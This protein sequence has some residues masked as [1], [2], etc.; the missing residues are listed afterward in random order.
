MNRFDRK[1]E[2]LDE[3]VT[4]ARKQ[5]KTKSFDRVMIS[6]GRVHYLTKDEMQTL[7]YAV[8]FSRK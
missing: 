2:L 1:P 4:R 8:K 5:L 7:E 3:L 6:M